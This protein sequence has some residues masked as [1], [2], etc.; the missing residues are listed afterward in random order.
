MDTFTGSKDSPLRLALQS[1]DVSPQLGWLFLHLHTFTE[2]VN[3]PFP[4]SFLLPGNDCE[5]CQHV[6][7]ISRYLWQI[8]KAHIVLLTFS[9][10]QSTRSTFII[11]IKLL[12]VC[13]SYSYSFIQRQPAELFRKGYF[14]VAIWT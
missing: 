9:P 12:R 1:L 13:L 8:L 5:M 6:G 11:H 7:H 2:Y 4:S 10:T 3:V 14:V